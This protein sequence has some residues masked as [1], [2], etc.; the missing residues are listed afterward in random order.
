MMA[1]S[2][3]GKLALYIGVAMMISS[4]SRNETSISLKSGKTHGPPE[5]MQKLQSMHGFMFSLYASMSLN[6]YSFFS[7]EITRSKTDLVF[8]CL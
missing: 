1:F 2:G 3:E 8:P 5:V 7:S 6:S 4:A